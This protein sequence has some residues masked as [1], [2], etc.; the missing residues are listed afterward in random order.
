MKITGKS[1]RLDPSVE[2]SIDS[3]DPKEF[4]MRLFSD[5]TAGLLPGVWGR[6]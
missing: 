5:G 6:Y 4:S 3:N 2:M 1:T